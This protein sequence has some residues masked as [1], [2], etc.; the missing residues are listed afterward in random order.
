MSVPFVDIN[1]LHS[2]LRYE[3]MV[4]FARVVDSGGYV[5]GAEVHA[6]EDE[7]ADSYGPSRALA[8]NSGTSA[9]HL[10]LKAC[11]VGPG[12]EVITT[13]NTFI[14]TAEAIS[15]C[16][17]T[18]VFADIA[19][20]GFNIDPLD[21]ERRVTSRTKAVIAVHL[22]GHIAPMAALQRI[23]NEHN[24]KLIEDAC[25]AHGAVQDGRA[26]GTIGDIGCLS[27]YPTKNLGTVGEGGM[28]LTDDP[29][30]AAKM[31]ELRDHGQ[32]SR[33]HHVEPGFN[34][35]MPELQAAALRTFLPH[36]RFWNDGRVRAAR[37][38]DRLLAGSA[39]VHPAQ[40]GAGEHVYHL[41]VIR[42]EDRAGLKEHLDAKGIATA[43]HY[44]TPIH[45]QP[46]YADAGS[47][48]GSLPQTEEAVSQILSLPMH[49]HLTESEIVQ[50]CEA[51][52]SFRPAQTPQPEPI[53]S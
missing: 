24:L 17:A 44:P 1:R 29:S 43:V 23:A 5:Q 19:P 34:Y 52:R 48:P 28:V 10:A 42:A 26:A 30:L 40:G 37:M 31:T 45:L 46:A 41:Y 53:R 7:F 47:G 3:L 12:D 2:S 13:A 11:G 27:F 9:L 35:R 21:V 39:V 16:G 38:Y 6:L 25:Q 49:P 33:H 14:A 20:G 18:P 8:V 32:V 22:Y 36:L 15:L 51:I 4:A 50:V